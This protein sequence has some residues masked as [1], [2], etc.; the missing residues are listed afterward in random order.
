VTDFYDS[1]RWGLIPAGARALLYWDGRYKATP[2][3]AKRFS[4]VRWITIAGGASSAAHT[5]AID[6]EQGNLAFEGGQLR[7]WAAARRAMGCRARVYTDLSN[8]PAAHKQVSDLKNVVWW[9]STLDGS[10]ANAAEMV[11]A[12]R[13]RD[14][15]L[16]PSQIWAVQFKGG[17]SAPYDESVLLGTW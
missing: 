7:A 4:A 11:T 3:D 2:A 16:T 17:P 14:V 6:F 1:A 5:G 8:L 10:P 15:D 12:A 13:E 9:L